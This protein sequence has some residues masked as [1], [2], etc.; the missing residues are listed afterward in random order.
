[1]LSVMCNCHTQPIRLPH[2]SHHYSSSY[3]W[4]TV[5]RIDG[6]AYRRENSAV[7][8]S[9]TARDHGLTAASHRGTTRLTQNWRQ[10]L[11]VNFSVIWRRRTHTQNQPGGPTEVKRQSLSRQHYSLLQWAAKNSVRQQRAVTVDPQW[12]RVHGVSLVT[13]HSLSTS[14]AGLLGAGAQPSCHWPRGGV[15][16]GQAASSSN[17]WQ[18]LTFSPAAYSESLIYV[19]STSLDC[20]RKDL[21]ICPLSATSCHPSTKT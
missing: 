16:S 5:I 20:R 11:N 3:M 9:V 21:S 14:K 6:F 8:V 7:D 2:F 12:I 4:K 10:V 1:M 13:H 19:T 17:G 18:T 15:N